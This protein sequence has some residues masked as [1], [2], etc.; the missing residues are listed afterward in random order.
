MPKRSTARSVT[1][2]P[3]VMGWNTVDP[4]SEMDPRY[5]VEAINFFSNG[6]TVDL[7]SGYGNYTTALGASGSVLGVFELALQ[8]GVRK[9]VGCG[10]DGTAY[11]CTTAGAGSSLGS[12]GAAGNVT[13]SGVNFRNRLFIKQRSTSQ[14]VYQWDGAAA[15]FSAA[16]F[17]GPSGDDKALL[18]IS[19]YKS[20]LYFLGNDASVWYGG[21]DSITGAL[22]QFDVQSVL[23]LGGKLYYGGGVQKTGDVNAEL[24]AFISDRGE[25][26][27][28]SGSYPG[29]SEWAL[30]GHY[31]M[32]PPVG[33]SAFFNWGANLVI[34]TY[35][36]LVLLSEVLNGG[37]SLTFLSEK[38]NDQFISTID[39]SST[40]LVMGVHYPKGNLLLISVNAG[41]NTGVQL[42][43]NTITGSWWK[44]T[45]AAAQIWGIWDDF[46]MF[47]A[48]NGAAAAV[49][50]KADNVYADTL[51][52]TVQS[53]SIKL[54][55]AYNYFGDRESTKQFTQAV[56]I[57]YQS[58]GL[59]LTMDADVDF[60]N[61]AA[62]QVVTP[63]T[64]DTAYKIY[65]PKVGLKGI[66]KCASIRIDQSVTTK[67]MSIQ[68]IEVQ[69]NE[70]D[71]Q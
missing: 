33:R 57:M 44:W 48:I 13:F 69:F 29:A 63:N 3:P 50:Q 68:A 5:A 42:V 16:A 22:T 26:L 8:S 53:R 2:P 70:G 66:G 54:R 55:P 27:L 45:I 60:A 15:S 23:T 43:M 7:R 21:I 41:N 19:V 35:Q 10:S 24:F 37:A 46:L 49:I 59:A 56:P 62:T 14:D 4:I 40:A 51:T 58:E 9:L 32:P 71:I 39:P 11:D 20:R 67:R 17:T 31:Y 64:A 38:I 30:V 6:A 61:V 36:G 65:Q 1:I 12:V 34:I 47:G 52:G 28:Y 25:V 18:G